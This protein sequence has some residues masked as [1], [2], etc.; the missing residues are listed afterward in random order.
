[1]SVLPA[2][3]LL[4]DDDARTCYAMVKLLAGEGYSLQGAVTC[5]AALEAARARTFDLLITDFLLPDGDGLGI[6]QQL[7]R[8]YPIEG[9]LITAVDTSD[10]PAHDGDGRLAGAARTSG[11]AGD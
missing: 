8:L 7:R 6:L 4:V 10:A 5:A 9:I 2:R 1:M 3:I 11:A